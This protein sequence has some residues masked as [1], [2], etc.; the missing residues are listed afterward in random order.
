MIAKADSIQDSTPRSSTLL[1]FL[2][3][4]A[5]LFFAPFAAAKP[6]P[7]VRLPGHV[8]PALAQATKLA[9]R[10]G[11][12][13]EPLTLTVVLKRDDQHGFERY[14]RDVYDPKSPFFVVSSTHRRSAPGSGPRAK[15][16]TRH[17]PTF[18]R[19]AS[20]RSKARRTG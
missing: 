10:P 5:A 19:M 14:L 13:Q 12:D 9:P 20:S 3:L 6:E 2:T 4:C 16:M 1:G 8:L 18:A 15:P 11:A 17:S 7:M